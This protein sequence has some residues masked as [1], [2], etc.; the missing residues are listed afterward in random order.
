[1][2][3]LLNILSIDRHEANFYSPLTRA[4]ELMLGA[5]LACGPIF[6]TVTGRA[7]SAGISIF[8][9]FVS[10]DLATFSTTGP[11]EAGL[12]IEPPSEETLE[13]VWL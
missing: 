5:A 6:G 12:D 9:V 8:E 10:V 1:L 3:F 4:W 11:T 2:S 7:F 13:L